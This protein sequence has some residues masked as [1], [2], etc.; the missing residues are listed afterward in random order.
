MYNNENAS[1]NAANQL[2]K[3]DKNRVKGIR[4]LR[5][6][7]KGSAFGNRELLKKLDQN[8]PQ[9]KKLRLFAKDGSSN[10]TAQTL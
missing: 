9:T 8:F 3:T 4:A 5:S 2:Y 7:T 6:A 1:D 10:Q